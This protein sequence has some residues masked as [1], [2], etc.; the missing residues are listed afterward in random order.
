MAGDA[1]PQHS[2]TTGPNTDPIAIG[3]TRPVVA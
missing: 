1:S 2:G 3:F